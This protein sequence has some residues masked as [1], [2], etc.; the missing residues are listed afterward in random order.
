VRSKLDYVAGR[1]GT[2]RLSGGADASLLDL[3]AS[4]ASAVDDEVDG[5][6][7]LRASVAGNLPLADGANTIHDFYFHLSSF[8]MWLAEPGSQS[9][10]VDVQVVPVMG[11]LTAGW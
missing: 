8:S 3:S 5:T 6:P 11:G 9:C 2:F 7:A 4:L 1:D 10:V